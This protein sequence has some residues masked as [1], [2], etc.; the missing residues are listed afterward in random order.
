MCSK[1]DSLLFGQV[2]LEEGRWLTES[3]GDHD[4]SGG[5]YFS[6]SA[7]CPDLAS[8]SSSTHVFRVGRAEDDF[9]CTMALCLAVN[10]S[11]R[12]NDGRKNKKEAV[13][14]RGEKKMKHSGTVRLCG[15]A[16]SYIRGE[17]GSCML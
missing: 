13:V 3:S 16:G 2:L 8:F 5:G 9:A 10:C 11:V 7:H 4:E 17:A 1:N 12:G 6:H 15:D 14:G